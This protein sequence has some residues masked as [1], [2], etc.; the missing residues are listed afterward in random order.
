MKINTSFNHFIKKSDFKNLFKIMKICLFLLFVFTFQMMAT[1]TNAQDAIIELKN[2]TVTVS[3]L[4]S[5]IE[6]QTDYLVVYSNREVDTSRKVNLKS[7]SDRVSEYLNEAFNGTNIVY[8]FENNYIVL[9]KKAEETASILTN[10][11]QTAQ[12]QGKT[13]RGT[14]TDSNGEPV[15]GATIVVKDNPTQG[16]VTDVDGN[17]ILSNLSEDAVISITYVGMRAQEIP[18]KGRKIINV[19]MEADTEVLEELVVVGYGTQRKANLT[20]AVDQ[21]T[22]E[23]FENRPISNVTQALQGAVPNL[24]IT[25]TDGKPNRSSSYNI[26]G[27]TSI[28]QGGSALVLIDGVEGDPAMLNPNDIESVSV[29][30]DAASAAIYGAR[31]TF[32]VVLI[33]T[34][35]PQ[36]GNIS[37]T[38][39]GNVSLKVPTSIPDIV[40]D[41]YTYAERFFEAYTA[42]NNYSATPKNINKT[43]TFTISWLEEFKN[44]KEQG[45]TE[46]VTVDQN[47]NYVYFGN[48]NYYNELYKKNTFAQDH[49]VSINGGTEKINYFLSGRFYDYNGLFKY[50]TDDYNM[51]NLRAKGSV[52]VLDWLTITNNTDFSNMKYHNPLNVGEGGSIWRNISDEG[53]PSSPIF[54]PDGTLTFSAAYTVGDF[55]YGKNG[56]DTKQN[57][58][59]NTTGFV[60]SFFNDKLKLIGDFTFRITDNNRTRRRV[61]VPYSKKVGEILW[62]STQY[63][64]L[65]EYVNSTNYLATNIYS[66]YEETFNNKHYVKGMVGW[67]Y[68]QS[69]YKSTTVMRNGL[70]MP[71]S[72]NINLALGE[73]ITTSGSYNKWRISGGFFRL[74]YRYQDRYLM[75]LNGRYDGSSKF[76]TDQQWAFFPSISA[77]WRITEEAFWKENNIISDIK[78]R[79]SYGSLGNGNISPYNFM[80][81]LSINTSGR[82]LNGLINK[83]TRAP[84]VMPEGLTWET[85]TTSDIGLDMGMLK[86]RLRFT[87]DYYIRKTKDMYTVGETLPDVFGASSPKGNYADMTTRGWEVSLTWRDQFVLASKPLN[88][89]V[90]FSLADYQSVIDRFNN[91]TKS[92]DDYNVGQKVGEIWGYET[93]G[94][95]QSQADIDSHAKQELIKSS[96][97]GI[98]YPGDVKI[99]DLDN[100]GVIDYGKNTLDDHGDKTI[101]GNELPRY[102]FSMNLGADWN[103]FFISAFFH[104]VGRQHWYPSQESVFWGQYNR[105]YNMLPTWHLNNYWT[106]D[107]PDAYLPRYAGYNT[108]IRNTPQ[109]R[110]LQNVAY[111][112]LKNLQVGYTIPKKRIAKA[113]LENARVYLSGENIWTW[114][115]LYNHT[116]DL[117]V[118][119]IYGSDRDLTNGT[120]GDGN[121]Y[122]TMQSF[123]VGLSLT[124]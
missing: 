56:I 9:S 25:L 51:Y 119:N 8:D 116:H 71:D 103:N 84:A 24:N 86:N 40:S 19:V 21:V 45:I 14:V 49:N 2:N 4:I 60:S 107:N 68:E 58:L 29:L 95:F 111:I 36:K 13:V 39:S 41:G 61:P 62:L 6:K 75:E 67:N 63:N 105:P 66:E 104:G 79:A 53:H 46:E 114:S 122:P 124:F 78:L 44:R 101:I 82:V 94:L 93:E 115:P 55:I 85:A 81:L 106:E 48:Q 22:S 110:Y 123:S 96:T 27:T 17:F 31:G 69:T 47:G 18:L 38:Y 108:S 121:N 65:E 43:Q 112:R 57:V 64:D 23:A 91:Q 11:V 7:K 117:D 99:R 42:W 3:Q 77:G 32:G 26:R 59:K 120:S 102:S 109:T 113:G 89:D 15:I 54:N 88:Y 92:L 30:K 90:R 83:I 16:T 20:G 76:P 1:N 5:E 70:L 52:E 87:G 37:V 97:K 10:L 100:S 80:E 74:N 33:T 72:K 35:T 50:N 34:K 98:E 73:S 12:Q 28:G 118:A